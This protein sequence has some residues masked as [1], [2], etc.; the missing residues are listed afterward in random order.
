MLRNLQIALL[1]LAGLAVIVFAIV[2]KQRGLSPIVAAVGVPLAAYTGFVAQYIFGQP[3][4]TES[5]FRKITVGV[6]ALLASSLS[7]VWFA[8]ALVIA[9][10]VCGIVLLC[11]HDLP[12]EPSS[13][14]TQLVEPAPP[15]FRLED[16]RPVKCSERPV[17]GDWIW[18]EETL[19]RFCKREL[20]A[21]FS[22]DADGA[23][24]VRRIGREREANR[25]S[26]PVHFWFASPVYTSHSVL[27]KSVALNDGLRSGALMYVLVREWPDAPPVTSKWIPLR[28]FGSTVGLRRRADEESD[29]A[30]SRMRF[31]A[32]IFP[33]SPAA[34]DTVRRANT[35]DELCSATP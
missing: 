28:S 2:V 4:H 33:V 8:N 21:I 23:E 32:V 34:T 20:L 16:W 12:L 3:G 25:C 9:I 7:R 18:D 15:P 5:L 6:W 26:G 29:I 35:L 1:V 11:V 22:G 31:V 19:S 27:P 14:N 13:A 24:Y 30:L 17:G 10:N